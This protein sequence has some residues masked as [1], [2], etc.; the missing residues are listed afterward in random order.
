M[1]QALQS[2]FQS[3][4][5]FDYEVIVVDNHSVDGSV[6]M[7]R[8]NF[9]QVRLIVN[10]INSGFSVANNMGIRQSK[11]EYILLLNPDTII[12][13]DT[14]QKI[15]G[16]ME[17]YPKTGGLGVKMMDGKGHFL[18][19]SKRGFPTPF[20]AFCKMSGLSTLFPKS[21]T[22][23]KYHVG[24]LDKEKNHPVDVLSGAC[25]LL[26]KSVLDQVGLLDEDYFMYG[27][28]IDLSYRI[29]EAGFENYYFADTE[30]I[31]F[32]GESTKKGSF[33]Y[34]KMFYNAMIIFTRKHLTGSSAN[35][36]ANLLGMAIYG[37]AA[38]AVI[39][40]VIGSIA[41]PLMDIAMIYTVMIGMK[42][43]WQSVVREG[44]IYPPSYILVNIPVYIAIWLVAYFLRG[45]YDP[46][47]RLRKIP[48]G[49][50]LGTIVILAV[51]ALLPESLRSSRGMI[52]TGAVLAILLMTLFRVVYFALI[53]QLDILT[54]GN[55]KILIVAQPQEAERIESLM[56]QTAL[57]HHVVG[58][59]HNQKE[60]SSNSYLGS[61]KDIPEICK[62]FGVDEIIFS[63]K[64]ITSREIMEVMSSLGSKTQYKIISEGSDVIIGSPSKNSAGELYTVEVSF[65]LNQVS[66]RRS[67]R[68]FDLTSALLLLLF[69]PL[70]FWF[71]KDKKAYFK[72]I[73]NVLSGHRTWVAYRPG[74]SAGLPPL[75]EGVLQVTDAKMPENAQQNAHVAYAKNYHWSQDLMR[76]RRL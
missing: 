19:E 20:V 16:F 8:S 18:P 43:F 63:L 50:A 44:T 4:T 51:Y 55:K 34:V 72:N 12:K 6:E 57:K 23:N 62:V 38:I 64:D 69:S 48:S 56:V 58:I 70:T 47:M 10:E 15:I 9:P 53:G 67:K 32:K 28:D 71:V 26:R 2:V 59:A 68:L 74:F 45:G 54:G 73:L 14:L 42:F 66:Y 75:R 31:H 41:W 22:F 3:E 33:N 17:L 11:G 76:L 5:E 7:V 52:L 27:E 1:E 37:R 36:L 39:R 49:I 61:A 46:P 65:H 40:R 21:A 35:R 60:F 25:M 30:I 13:E 29:K 24:H